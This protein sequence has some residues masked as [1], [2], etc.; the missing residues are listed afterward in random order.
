MAH[1]SKHARAHV[2]D[3]CVYLM[4]SHKCLPQLAHARPR[5]R[6]LRRRRAFRIGFEALRRRR[7]RGADLRRFRFFAFRGGGAGL[8]GRGE[9]VGRCCWA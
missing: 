3:L 7:A 2:S 8:G 5:D 1:A 9:G 6:A 4:L